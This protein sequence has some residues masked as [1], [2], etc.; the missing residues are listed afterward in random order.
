MLQGAGLLVLLVEAGQ[1]DAQFVRDHFR[2]AIRVAVA[3]ALHAGHVAHHGLRAKRAEGDDLRNRALAV[4][5][6][7]VVDY[8]AAPVH[9][10]V[11]VDIGRADALGIEEALEEQLE[12]DRIDVRD[13]HRVG[14]HRAGR[15]AAPRTHG[16]AMLFR[17]MDEIPNDEEVIGEALFLEDADLE[18]EA[19]AHLGGIRVRAVTFAQSGL[20]DVAQILVLLH[21]LGRG[22]IRILGRRVDLDLATLGDGQRVVAGFGHLG[23]KRAHLRGRLEIDL[24]YVVEAALVGDV[25]AG[26][27][28]DQRIVRRVVRLVE[29]VHVV[30]RDQPESEL[31]GQRGQHPVAFDLLLNSVI[32]EL[33]IEVFRPENIAVGPRE[34]LRLGQIV[35]D[36][37][38]VDFALEAAAQ[39]DQP[40]RVLREQFLVDARL[41]IHAVEVRDGDELHEVSVA[42]VVLRQ[43]GEVIGRFALR[44]RRFLGVRIRGHVHFATDDRVDAR[45]LRL[46][47]KFDRAEEVAV[48]RDGQRRHPVFLR[49]FHRLRDPHRAVERRVFGMAVEMDKRVGR[50]AENLARSGATRSDKMRSV[51]FTVRVTESSSSVSFLS[52]IPLTPP[53]SSATL[54]RGFT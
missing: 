47:V 24:L 16:N 1:G 31:P 53:A 39:P 4:L 49:F 21:A 13:P 29:K 54:H 9:A 22:V 3:P 34:F 50:H 42:L 43:Q 26:A 18:F 27:D 20:G 19:L 52:P 10:E 45:A 17:P 2:H 12:L 36:D 15:R 33:N 35:L 6:A 46:L 5:L 28:A 14:D 37:R 38:G 25:R 48:V 51:D 23:E 40:L 11:H 44:G 30:R 8:F 32:M 7:H 41:V